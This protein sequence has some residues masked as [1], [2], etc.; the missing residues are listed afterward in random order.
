MASGLPPRP[1]GQQACCPAFVSTCWR[2]QAPRSSP[3]PPGAPPWSSRSRCV[4]PRDELSDDGRER[5]ARV[6][7]VRPLEV[8]V[9][10]PFRGGGGGGEGSLGIRCWGYDIGDTILG[11]RLITPGWPLVVAE[12]HEAE[13]GSNSSRRAAPT[14]AR[15]PTRLALSISISNGLS[16]DD[17]FDRFDRLDTHGMR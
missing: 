4:V 16:N 15:P 8:V 3:P 14:N 12:R 13:L 7:A 2:S 9:D 6:G 1:G 17:R 11:I 10:V 5:E